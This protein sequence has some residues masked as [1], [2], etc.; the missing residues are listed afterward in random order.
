MGQPFR[1]NNVAALNIRALNKSGPYRKHI[2]Y[3]QKHNK[4]SKAKLR[5]IK[6]D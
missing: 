2:I 5:K 1:P 6:T 3:I 4:K